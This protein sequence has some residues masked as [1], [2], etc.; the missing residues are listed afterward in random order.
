LALDRK[1]FVDILTEGQA[2]IGGAMLPP[3]EGVWGMPPETLRT[4]PGYNPEVQKNREQARIIM[5]KLGYGPDKRLRVKIA[6]R[7]IPV[8]RDPAVI[9]IDQL[10]EIYIDAEMDVVETSI[11]HAKVTRK[12]YQVGLNLTG[13]G[14]DDPDQNF[15]ENYKCGSERN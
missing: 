13:N 8:Y 7:N 4:L 9:L 12:D 14:V 6:T 15:Y 3:P 1:A 11:W 2:K 10:K 5:Q